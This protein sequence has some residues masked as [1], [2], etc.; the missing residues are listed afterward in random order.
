MILII[1]TVP[2]DHFLVLLS[3]KRGEAKIKKVA[4][5][6]HQAEKILPT[7]NK[8]LTQEKIK[9]TALK[10]IGVVVGPGGFT[11]VRVG[12]AT[13]NALGYALGLPIAGIRSDAFSTPQELAI[14]VYDWIKKN[15]KQNLVE[16]IYDR[17]PNITIKKS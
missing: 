13:A 2:Q 12:V 14:L 5:S 3:R 9:T 4:G 10:G 7:I 15:P 1:N 16:P 6:F 11:S 17:E 8:L